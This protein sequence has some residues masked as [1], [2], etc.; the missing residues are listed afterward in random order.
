MV[1][2]KQLLQLHG[3]VL[4]HV[5]SKSNHYKVC[6]SDILS[7]F[8]TDYFT[9]YHP[10]SPGLVIIVVHALTYVVDDIKRRIVWSDGWVATI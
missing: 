9:R 7:T 8:I 2:H 6:T 4:C 3:L 10:V 1:A 5:C